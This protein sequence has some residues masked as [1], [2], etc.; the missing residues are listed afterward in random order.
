MKEIIYYTKFSENEIFSDKQ[1]NVFFNQLYTYI[2]NSKGFDDIENLLIDGNVALA[3]Q[4]E[5][6]GK[7]IDSIL[8]ST[9]MK[10]TFD[11]LKASILSMPIQGYIK[12][13]SE[14]KFKTYSKVVTIRF[15]ART[16]E[17]IDLDG[18]KIRKMSEIIKP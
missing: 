11:F 10:S 3:L 2:I 17:S 1:L 18:I 16:M 7:G 5:P 4:G 6:Y 14:L 8:L 9:N 13:D 15:V 12:S